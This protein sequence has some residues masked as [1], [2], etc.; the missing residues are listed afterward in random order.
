VKDYK[1][2][3][4][5]IHRVLRRG[6]KLILSTPNRE[7]GAF[8][9]ETD[10]EY[11][12]HEFSKEELLGL[13]SEY[14]ASS[15][16]YGQDLLDKRSLILRRLRRT[17]AGLLELVGLWA[18]GIWLGRLLFGHNHRVIYKTED[19]DNLSDG[20]GEVVPLTEDLAPTTFVVV[21]IKP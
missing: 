13:M 17:A 14:F 3:L 12:V 8:M 11:H 7:T 19:F 21:A 9:F 5:E 6:G 18:L 1:G 2:F 20:E 16:V 10:W 4:F 15:A